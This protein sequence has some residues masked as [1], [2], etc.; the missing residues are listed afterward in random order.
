MT[1]E[2]L[3]RILE[4]RPQT[5]NVCIENSK[6]ISFFAKAAFYLGLFLVPVAIGSSLIFECVIY[7]PPLESLNGLFVYSILLIAPLSILLAVIAFI[8]L[9]L[10]KKKLHGCGFA[11][12]GLVLA[13]GSFIMT[14]YFFLTNFHIC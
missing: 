12:L 1:T 7:N 3:N 4:I 6:R 9:A 5:E 14:A 2:D 10:S 8:L 13:V 11:T